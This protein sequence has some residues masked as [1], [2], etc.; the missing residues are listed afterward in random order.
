MSRSARACPG[1]VLAESPPFTVVTTAVISGR[2]AVRAS[3]RMISLAR[4]ETALRPRA[5]SAPAWAGRPVSSQ[6]SPHRAL[7]RRH[8]I[9]VLAGALEHDRRGGALGL[10]SPPPGTAAAPPRRRRSGIAPRRTAA[11][12]RRAAPSPSRPAPAR[13]SC[14]PRPG[15]VQ[16][17]PE[18]ANGRRAA[19]PSPNTVSVCPSRATARP[20]S[21]ASVITR[22]RAGPSGSSTHALVQPSG[23]SHGFDLDGH[24]LLLPAVGR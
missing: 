4:A 2:P 19:S 20:P 6:R 14:R 16:R 21:P 17:S 11:A 15:P 5:V 22:L 1:T 23:A 7:A 9:A 24:P 18:T 8:Q 12:R 10:V 13:P 3:I